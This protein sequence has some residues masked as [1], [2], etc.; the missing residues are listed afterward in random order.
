MRTVALRRG[1]RPFYQLSHNHCPNQT[2]FSV[3]KSNDPRHLMY[4]L[5]YDCI[6]IKANIVPKVVNFNNVVVRL[7]KDKS[8]IYLYFSFYKFC[9][10]FNVI[11]EGTRNTSVSSWAPPCAPGER[12]YLLASYKGSFQQTWSATWLGHEGC[13]D[14]FVDLHHCLVLGYPI[15]RSCTASPKFEKSFMWSLNA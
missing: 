10:I 12:S 14:I 2:N 7:R 3:I 6:Y 13:R 4:S 5:I 15:S 11:T 9:S 8:F 1:K